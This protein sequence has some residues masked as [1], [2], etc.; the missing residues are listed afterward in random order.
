MDR[1]FDK[2][3]LMVGALVVVAWAAWAQNQTVKRAAPDKDSPGGRFYLYQGSY[4][5]IEEDINRKRGLFYNDGLFKID[6]ATGDV[7]EFTVRAEE[8][9]NHDILERRKWVKLRDEDVM[10]SYDQRD[11]TYT[12]VP[13]Q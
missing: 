5:V 9:Q 11:N 6:S 2:R 10:L 3:W 1:F 7:W 13:E 8:Q 12:Q 4:V